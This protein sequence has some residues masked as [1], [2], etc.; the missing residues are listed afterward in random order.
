MRRAS[1][2]LASAAAV[3]ACLTGPLTGAAHAQ[4][5]RG[6]DMPAADAA[7]IPYQAE[8]MLL[9]E[10]HA[11]ADSPLPPEVQQVHDE[12]VSFTMGLDRETL[13]QWV[14]Q[15]DE[16]GATALQRL[17]AEGTSPSPP[18]VRTLRTLSLDD[19]AAVQAG[20]TISISATVYAGAYGDL[21]DRGGMGPS[22]S[23][24]GTVAPF[25]PT[26]IAIETPTV[27]P[28]VTAPPVAATAPR[29]VTTAA[30]TPPAATAP[31][32]VATTAPAPTPATTAAPATTASSRPATTAASTTVAR[33]IDAAPA[34][35][36][37][38]SVATSSGASRPDAADIVLWIAIGVAAAAAVALVIVVLRRRE[39]EDRLDDTT[40]S[41]LLD[42]GKRLTTSL[43]ASEVTQRAVEEAMAITS[44]VAGA[45]VVR[46]GGARTVSFTSVDAVLDAADLDQGVVARALEAGQAG[47]TVLVDPTGRLNRRALL[48]APAVHDGQV[49]GALA[50]SRPGDSPFTAHDQE[51][52]ARLA[53]LVAAALHT[54]G[55]HHDS[56]EL[57]LV[58]GLTALG[59]RR[60]LERDL[61]TA[62]S[63]G[64]GPVAFVMVDVDH[65]K[66]Y[67]DTHGHVAGDEALRRVADALRTAV[68]EG[69]V[70]YRYGGEEF[71]V[72]LPDTSS[73][74]A[75]AVCERL[76]IAVRDTPFPGE[77]R[78]PSG[79]VTVSV[80]VALARGADVD[81][82][83][84]RADEA[85][86]EAK[87]S[88][89]D[90][91]VFA[92]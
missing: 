23:T 33:T 86:Y 57:A 22:G 80:G 15:A 56:A 76:R 54:A 37:S 47:R 39:P 81:A 2:V 69:D 77:E 42:A 66:V 67:N 91:V 24:A 79:R 64:S 10:L 75:E 63:A 41:R 5:V 55:R 34:S 44:A 43:E 7:L 11:F 14:F 20:G 21:R 51:A 1:T 84:T 28:V 53:P 89:R 73:E 4:V 3:L 25:E 40:V 18:V 52:L 48:A 90:R 50:V 70:V 17:Q 12:W 62:L 19:R 92:G 83:K 26:T 87:R 13:V 72:L 61:P 74:E 31:T 32:T 68:R 60:R 45:Y 16:D 71:C 8:I 30:S 88:G 35:A 49:V 27:P 9:V 38:T 58:D 6:M 82:L 36:S 78:Q 29:A 85:L 59:N 46:D 65:F